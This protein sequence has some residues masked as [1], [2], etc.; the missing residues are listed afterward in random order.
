M[1]MKK[2]FKI[3]MCFII[4]IIL[5]LLICSIIF[6]LANR[7]I[8]M[9]NN[10]LLLTYETLEPVSTYKDKVGDAEYTYLQYGADIGLVII[11][12][13][14]SEVIVQDDRHGFFKEYKN[15]VL[16]YEDDFRRQELI[17]KIKSYLSPKNWFG[18]VWHTNIGSGKFI[19]TIE[20]CQQ[21]GQLLQE[22]EWEQIRENH[23]NIIIQTTSGTYFVN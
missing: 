5:L 8:H 4:F 20:E 14:G 23:R 21:I 1:H 6:Y 13:D 9:K 15:G 22:E 3:K 2:S 16:Y 7:H 12:D 11:R 19:R 17:G 10:D 18:S